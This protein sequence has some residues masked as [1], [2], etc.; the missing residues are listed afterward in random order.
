MKYCECFVL[1]EGIFCSPWRWE[2]QNKE[3]VECLDENDKQAQPVLCASYS[4]SGNRKLRPSS[5]PSIASA[6]VSFQNFHS[7]CVSDGGLFILR[8]HLPWISSSPGL[9]RKIETLPESK[10]TNFSQFSEIGTPLPPWYGTILFLHLGQIKQK[11]KGRYK[12]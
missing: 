6:L 8:I 12:S 3:R 1:L 11:S 4:L 9:G 5:A 7:F 10:M 2:L